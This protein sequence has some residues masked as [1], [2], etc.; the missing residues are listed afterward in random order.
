MLGLRAGRVLS[1]ASRVARTRVFSRE[2][3]RDPQN[4]ALLVRMW[5]AL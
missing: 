5:D 4:V 2:I 1:R 3:V